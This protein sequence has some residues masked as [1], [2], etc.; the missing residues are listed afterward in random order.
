MV[1]FDLPIDLPPQVVWDYLA[2]PYFRNVFLDADRVQVAD[3]QRGRVSPGATFQCYHGDRVVPQ[4]ILEWVPFSRMVTKDLISSVGGGLYGLSI[5][6]LSQ[7]ENGTLLKFSL[8]GFTGPLF[9]R[10]LAP[11]VLK[12]MTR[13]WV[14][15]VHEF[16]E[17]IEADHTSKA[18]SLVSTSQGRSSSIGRQPDG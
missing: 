9:L 11:V 14:R 3:R 12:A 17:V 15:N 4:L 5:F 1:T 7:T 2:D 8:A 16:G 18:R 10:L 13:S 6:E